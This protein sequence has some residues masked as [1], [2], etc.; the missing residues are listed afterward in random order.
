MFLPQSDVDAYPEE[1]E[2]QD[3]IE[4]AWAAQ[5]GG[6]GFDRTLVATNFA[7]HPYMQ[8]CQR[9]NALTR[10]I[11]GIGDA[12]TIVT[13]L[14]IGLSN[15]LFVVCELS[16]CLFYWALLLSIFCMLWHK[17]CSNP[18]Y[19]NYLYVC[20]VSNDTHHIGS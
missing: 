4:K 20:F 2:E 13:G 6:Q 17:L 10:W 18:R 8:V 14:V 11:R 3:K 7:L 15:M 12:V 19:M 1:D 5:K 9:F 16:F